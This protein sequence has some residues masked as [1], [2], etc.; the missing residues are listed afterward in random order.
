[1]IK[2]ETE[3]L[4]AKSAAALFYDSL[5]KACD[6]EYDTRQQPKFHEDGRTFSENCF[7]C[8]NRQKLDVNRNEMRNYFTLKEMMIVPYDE[9]NP[10][11][12]ALLRAV[13]DLV[14]PIG[15]PDR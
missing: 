10:E 4:S 2:S 8:A 12:E 1:M 3:D 6:K 14:F 13:F 5:Q 15:S 9:T 11:H 7:C